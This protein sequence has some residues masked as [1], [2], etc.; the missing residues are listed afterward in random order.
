MQ[1]KKMS[2]KK[3]R[4]RK[5]LGQRLSAVTIGDIGEVIAEA[6][7]PLRRFLNVE[8]KRFDTVVASSANSTAG[9]VACLSLIAEG[10]DYNN[11]DGRSVR[12]CAFEARVDMRLDPAKA[13][14]DTVR[15]VLFSDLENQG[16]NPAVTDVLTAADP[17][18][19]FNADNLK[20]F[21][22]FEDIYVSLDTYAGQ[23]K[24]L[25]IKLPIDQHLRYRGA[26]GAIASAAEGNLFYLVLSSSAVASTSFTAVTSRVS[27]VDN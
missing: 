24:V 25:S 10:G 8:T 16:A 3:P 5:T 19:T 6:A 26:T 13:L 17:Q 27:F 14:A 1:R 4:G 12:A 23:R 20:R 11:R 22:V 7:G 21:L 9:G 18:S 2:T 15:F